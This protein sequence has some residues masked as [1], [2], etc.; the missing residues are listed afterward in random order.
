MA[1]R[2]SKKCRDFFQYIYDKENKDGTKLRLL[3]DEY[4]LC[5]MVGLASGT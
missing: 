5:L 1:F 3:F 4:Y 2:L